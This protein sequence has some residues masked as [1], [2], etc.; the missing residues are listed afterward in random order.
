MTEQKFQAPPLPKAPT[1]VQPIAGVSPQPATPFPQPAATV[2]LPVSNT[3][4]DT[5]NSSTESTA[6]VTTGLITDLN[7]PLQLLQTKVVAGILGGV[8]LF[9]IILGAMM[10]GGSA[11]PAQNSGLQGIVRNPEIKQNIPRCGMADRTASCILYIV[12]ASRNDRLA[13]DFF[14]EAVK[15]TGRQKYLLTIENSQYAKTRIAPGYF[16]QIK[17]PA[18]K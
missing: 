15:L 2:E 18:L 9:G 3:T 17:V 13:E 1:P 11:S 7:L 5:P 8:L 16:A 6:S 14:D 12:N 10:F 4:T